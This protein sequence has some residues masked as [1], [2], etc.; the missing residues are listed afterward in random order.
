MPH[1]YR[2]ALLVDSLEVPKWVSDF[3]DWARG[4]SAIELAALVVHSPPDDLFERVLRLERKFLSQKKEYRPY[5]TLRSIADAAPVVIDAR[6]GIGAASSLR[7]AELE[8][9]AILFCGRGAA[10]DAILGASRDGIISVVAGTG[11]GFVEV[12]DGRADT[13]F[14]IERQRNPSGYRD[15]MFS[16][17]VSTALLYGWNAT[18]LQA[19]AFPYLRTVLE[20]LASGGAQPIE[21]S[22]AGEKKP[23]AADLISYGL[24]SVRRSLGKSYRR[25]SGRE[26][27]FQ[28]AFARDGWPACKF[29]QGAPIPNPP[30]AF[31]ADPFTVSVNGTD[32]LFVEEFPFDTRKG[33][34]SAY[35]LGDG[36]AHRIGV[37]LEE[38]YH[39]SF[40][41][42]FEYGAIY[43]WS[44]RARPTGR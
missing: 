44:R 5:A 37:V 43:T 22:C 33:V 27:N 12:L 30:G 14:T 40:P 34:I 26:F 9:D 24:R 36:E 31:L 23:S 42:V 10:P 15:V 38:P 20:Q 18:A 39:L 13:P 7:I 11:G 19:R 1:K 28:V 3:A 25:Y 41:F 17:S 29:D 2:I 32:Y 6:S 21:R 35:R 8:L 4:H 16:G